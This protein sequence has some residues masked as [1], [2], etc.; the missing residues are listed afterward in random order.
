MT[1]ATELAK[2][3]ASI[4]YV[5]CIEGIG[6]P[7]DEFDLT[8]GF[9]G[10]LFVTDDINSDHATQ[11]PAA[12]MHRG[13]MLSGSISESLDPRTCK[14]T[15]GSMS[16]DLV[17]VDDFVH[18]VFAQNVVPY[19]TT[20]A[21]AN[22]NYYDVYIN[23]ADGTNFANG[24]VAWLGRREA[25]LLSDKTNIAG[26]IFR[27]LVTRGYLGTTRGRLDYTP[28]GASSF[29]WIGVATSNIVAT[30]VRSRNQSWADRRVNL[31]MHV[32]GEAEDYCYL[33][34][35][36]RIK[37]LSVPVAAAKYHLDTSG[38]PMR[39]LTHIHRNPTITING[40]WWH[41]GPTASDYMAAAFEGTQAQVTDLTAVECAR[42]FLLLGVAPHDSTF[43][44]M[45]DDELAIRSS[46]LYRSEPGG[47]AGMITA[48]WATP[49]GADPWTETLTINN[50]LLDINNTGTIIKMLWRAAI[51]VDGQDR[52]A[53]LLECEVSATW[54]GQW[55]QTIVEA[56]LPCK[57][58]LDNWNDDWHLNRF[59]SNRE[60]MRHPIDVALAFMTTMPNEFLRADA[61]AGSTATVIQFVSTGGANL[62]VGATLFCVEGSNK[63]YCRRII[64]NDATSI[65][66]ERAFPGAPLAGNEFQV[67][68]TPYDALPL[69]WGMAIHWTKIDIESF[70]NIRDIWM[71]GAEVGRFAIGQD[72]ETD[73]WRLIK[74]NIF[75]AYGVLVHM[76]KSTGKITARY[77]GALAPVSGIFET[78]LG[79]DTDDIVAVG[80]LDYNLRKLSGKTI[81]EIRN[82]F[83]VV[84]GHYRDIKIIDPVSGLGM[85]KEGEYGAN[86]AD[87]P[88]LDPA[89]GRSLKVSLVDP[90][91]ESG[92]ADGKADLTIKAMLNTNQGDA[93]VVRALASGRVLQYSVPVATV[94]LDLDISF[95]TTLTVGQ[96]CL[97]DF[98]AIPANPLNTTRGWSQVLMRCLGVTIP[99]MAHKPV[100]RAEFELLTSLPGARIAPACDVD[101]IGVDGGGVSYFTVSAGAY[102]SDPDNDKDYWHFAVTDLIEWR[103]RTGALKESHVIASF[104]SNYSATPE[105]AVDDK[106]NVV[107]AFAAARVAGDYVTF[108]PWS[109]GNTARMNSYCAFA[110]AAGTLTGGATAKKYL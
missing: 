105:G 15:Y 97:V 5:L 16:F 93:D 43:A 90:S 9:V 87:I 60:I 92:E 39:G 76:S 35:S 41:S 96:Y 75:D 88:D 36:G 55:G 65:T 102:V 100:V 44:A 42:Q 40:S 71:Q 98:A 27:Y 7:L 19:E 53:G 91:I 108:Q 6:W 95:I 73:L 25:V 70:E 33:V 23:L 83:G 64:A 106:I 18:G 80:E 30:K 26:T 103:D 37:G 99:V 79:I 68:N 4:E 28:T 81:L 29:A 50:S 47:T 67:R 46:Y 69:G 86:Y 77:V 31:Y 17:D 22:T 84:V 12:T 62:W 109:A 54:L 56:G 78:F 110:N 51:G 57:I 82:S 2:G 48:P 13:L 61:Q 49:Q 11:F 63:G 20:I 66:V 58:L 3:N 14:Y 89:Q 38:D 94:S 24:D 10:D 34:Y 1:V 72:D 45:P 8:Q 32:P 101:A 21:V 74:E 85:Y 107:G 59:A 52:Q 104:G